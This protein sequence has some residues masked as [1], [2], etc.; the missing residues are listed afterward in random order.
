[1]R[2]HHMLGAVAAAAML[3]SGGVAAAAV[4]GPATAASPA[5]PD[6]ETVTFGVYLPMRNVTQLESL[7]Q[8]LNTKGSPSYQKW[9]TPTEAQAQFAP[10]PAVMAQA[11]AI[12]TQAGFQIVDSNPFMFHVTGSASQ[13]SRLLQANLK[14]V[15][16]REGGHRVVS[17]NPTITP[18]SLAQ[19]GAIIP[20]FANL[21]EHHVHSHALAKPQGAD[22]ATPDNRNG[23]YGGYRYNDMK[24]A[25]DYPAYSALDGKGVNVAIVMSSDALDGDVA[26]MFNWEH[27]STTTG[28]APPTLVHVSID[29][30]LPAIPA[31]ALN[32]GAFYEA[33]LDSQM[34]TGGAPGATVTM[35]N[36]P[37]LSDSS[38]WDAY[39]TAV[40]SNTYDIVS[41]SFGGCESAYLASYNAGV[42][43]T[44][45][46]QYYHQIFLYGAAEGITF[47]ASSGDSGALEC[48]SAA[49]FY[50][51]TGTSFVA[52]VSTP[53]SDPLVTAVGGGNLQT[54]YN[55]GS[56]DSAYVSENGWGDPEI[57]YDPYGL[58]AISGGYWGAGGGSSQVFAQPRYQITAYTHTKARAVPDIGMQV[59]GCPG[60]IA[61]LPCGPGRSYV[62]VWADYPGYVG[63]GYPG[64]DAE[65][66]LIGTSVSAPEFAG[67]LALAVQANH[68][69]LGQL[70]YLLYAEGGLQT[71]TGGAKAPRPLQFFHQNIPGFDGLYNSNPAGGYNFIYGNGSPDVRALFGLNHLPAA[72]LP[73]TP[74]NP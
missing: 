32:N 38:I 40:N 3:A 24:Q 67:A 25:Y 10:S 26:Q 48:P 60:G 27:Y 15:P 14:S 49:Y 22:G 1:M 71:L 43:Y 21:P 5:T 57:P 20:E 7:I 72:G 36:I 17:L 23:P 39:L 63:A 29:G 2:L 65:V 56:L 62:I 73:R 41:S 4:Q 55:A 66:G 30:A 70:N 53:A 33:S 19:L 16:T 50:G 11:Q 64:T 34:V 6:S 45:L 31:T 46:L 52:G 59:G 18:A 61:V 54:T 8:S 12:V 47:L 42:D 68:H 9:L 13:V 35:L 44:Y 74:S 51:A 28:K 58:G 69:R 37:D